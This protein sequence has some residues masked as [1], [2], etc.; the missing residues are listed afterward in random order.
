MDLFEYI[1]ASFTYQNNEI[2]NYEKS[3]HFY[4]YNRLLSIKYPNVANFL[5]IMEI[6]S[7]KA[8]DSIVRFLKNNGHNS[9]PKFFYTKA[10]PKI[11]D[12]SWYPKNKEHLNIYLNMNKYSLK[13]F[14]DML[15][16]D[17]IGT[18]KDFENFIE[19]IF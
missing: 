15:N 5:N 19:D 9:T 13:L 16:V 11:A 3:K 10:K 14:N 4:M 7:A 17:P 12:K 6:P 18:K 2:T 1:E 8:V